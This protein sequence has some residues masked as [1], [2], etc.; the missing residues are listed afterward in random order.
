[1]MHLP[2]R[3]P[4]AITGAG[5]VTPIGIGVDEFLAGWRRGALG[6]TRPSWAARAPT[7]VL[8]AP[9]PARFDP[10][11]V[12]GERVAAGTDPAAQ[13]AIVAAEEALERAGLH[14]P[15]ALDPMRTAVIDGNAALGLWTL[16]HAQ[17][18]FDRE[19]IAGIPPKAMLAGQSN[20]AAAQ[21]A[22]RH[23][24]HGPLRTVTT[25]CASSLD[26]LGTAVDLLNWGRSDVAICGGS[27]AMNREAEGFVPVFS[28]AGRVVGIETPVLDPERASIPFDVERRGIIFGEGAAWFILETA[29]HAEAR[30]VEPLG[31][32]LGVGSCADGYHPVSPEPSGRWQA[33]AME[34]ALADAG[35]DAEQIDLVLAHATGT[36]QGD[37]AEARALERVFSRR[38]VPP[39]VTALKG[40]T[41]HTGG[42]SAA[43]SVLA[44]LDVLRTGRIEAVRGTTVVDPAMTIDVVVGEP[45]MID[46][47]I[48]MVNAFGFGGQNACIV[49]ASA[50]HVPDEHRGAR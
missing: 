29:D 48:A 17:H 31:W 4:I 42:S 22:I 40:N 43:M 39:P 16:L 37:L 6:I 46:A 18:C 44:A 32:V 23:E 45:R 15:G 47:R 35:I 50:A 24:L 5:C 28:I 7:P 1:M 20:M 33:H 19:G 49:I 9:V 38:P 14:A 3:R 26:A 34:L 8:A 2:D 30:G 27:E 41:G 12:L 11:P 25:A 21:I 36:V 10:V 13:F